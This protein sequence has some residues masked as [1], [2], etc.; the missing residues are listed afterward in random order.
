MALRSLR[1]KGLLLALAFVALMAFVVWPKATPR[2]YPD[3]IPV[4]YWHMWTAEWAD[5]IQRICDAFN[6]SQSTYEVIPLIIPGSVGDTKPLLGVAGGDPPD[7]MTHWASVIPS[8]AA[9]DWLVP[10]DA[11][12]SKEELADFERETYPVARQIG[13]YRGRLFAIGVGLNAFGLYYLPDQLAEVGVTPKTFP[14]TLEEL[15]D[16]GTKLNQWD[17]RGNLTRLGFQPS[18]FS[19]LCES[20]GGGLYDWS[21]G[22]LTLNTP[23]NLRALEFITAERKKVGFETVNRFN[24]GLDTGSFAGGWPFIGGALSITYDGQWRVEQIGKY[25]PTLNYRTI[26]LPPPKGGVP[27]AGTTNG[28]FMI[29]PRGAKQPQGAWEFIKFWSGLSDPARAAKF[30]TWGGW[31]PINDRIAQSPDYR[32][33]LRRYPQ[34]QTFVDVLRS[35]HYTTLP[36]VAYQQFLSDRATRAEDLSVRGTLAPREALR[37]FEQEVAHEIRRRKELGYVE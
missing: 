19:S 36:P 25:A 27:L 14:R 23:E 31:L 1:A 5:V 6:E 37:R 32:A 3:R 26:P 20:Y 24:A 17:K 28:N 7:V 30:Y 35:P 15:A 18:W 9:A 33:Y 4:R 8:W 29:I 11:F 34:F 21:T 13:M 22:R 10:L 2:K 16:L 12:M